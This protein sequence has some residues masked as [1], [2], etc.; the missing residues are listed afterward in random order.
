VRGFELPGATYDQPVRLGLEEGRVI[1]CLIEKQ[2]TTP[3]QYPLTLNALVLA[4]NQ[5]SN[6]DPVV[7][8]DDRTVER[9]L[10]WLKDAGLVHFVHPSHGRSATRY[11]Q[12]LDERLGL[13]EPSLALVAVLLLRG[14]QTAGELRARTERMATFDGIAAVD[15]ELERMGGG[16]KPLVLRLPRRPGQK[17]ERWAHLLTPTGLARVD[18]ADDASGATSADRVHDPEACAGAFAPPTGPAEDPGRPIGVDSRALGGEQLTAIV[19]EVGALRAE[20]AALRA[21]VEEL[22]A[23]PWR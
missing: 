7:R 13:D 14:P 5:S 8:Y 12:A 16:S 10:A 15:V 1:G 2:L 23:R 20:V 6:R 4:C 19:D 3:Q 21:A 11:R 22:Q 18:T 9:A 17:E